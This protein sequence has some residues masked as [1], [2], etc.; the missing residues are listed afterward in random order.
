MDV[1]RMVWVQG[2]YCCASAATATARIQI[3]LG[4]SC[5]LKLGM[6]PCT[7]RGFRPQISRRGRWRWQ[8][9]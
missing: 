7:C 9:W 6:P 2:C 3:A 4:A 8:R 5:K 1:C